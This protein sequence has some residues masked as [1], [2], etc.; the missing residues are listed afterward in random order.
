MELI[1]KGIFM[2]PEK[3]R[4][5]KNICNDQNMITALAIDQR[6][7]LLK[8]ISTIDPDKSTPETVGAF[9]VPVSEELTK[10]ASSILLDPQVGIEA[11]HR[12]S[13]N[14]GLLLSYEV[15]GYAHDPEWRR[16]QLLDNQSVYRLKEIGADGIKILL[17]YDVDQEGENNQKRAFIERVGGECAA[18]DIP[19][20]LEIVTYDAYIPDTKSEAYAKVKPHKV[21]KSM[22]VFS[23]PKYQVD[24]LKME[25]PVN[26]KF[27]EGFGE[28][29]LYTKE[30]AQGF[31]KDQSAATHLPYIF[32]SAGVSI[33]LFIDT[34]HFAKEA[35]AS[36][37]G[38]LCGRATWKDAL[39]PYILE[40]EEA[41][42]AWLKTQGT[43]NIQRLNTA[44]AETATAI[45]F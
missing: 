35:G 6:D 21:I 2:T 31:F 40:G 13:E 26:M 1:R 24:V 10:Y 33:D 14:A 45:H 19:F 36:Y 17:Y 9:K 39:P 27:V 12:R 7:S 18:Y 32:L 3:S 15:S 43:E 23:D 20:F 44:V 29:V 34:L 8:M 22:K 28:K 38:V 25:V 4:H 16:P 41:S 30:E 5:L 11:A 42:R 37:H